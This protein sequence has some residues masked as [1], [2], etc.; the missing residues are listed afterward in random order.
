MVSASSASDQDQHLESI[1]RV[2]QSR[3]RR[4]KVIDDLGLTVGGNQDCIGRKRL[5]GNSARFFVRHDLQDIGPRRPHKEVPP[6]RD[7][8]DIDDR[9]DRDDRPHRVDDRENEAE[10]QEANETEQSPTLPR[11]QEALN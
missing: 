7:A 3:D 11:G 1:H 2:L 10:N 9:H 6:V 4:Q 5:I 8:D